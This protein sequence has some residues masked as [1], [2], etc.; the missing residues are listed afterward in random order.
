LSEAVAANVTTALQ[1]PAVAFAVMF[2]GQEIVGNW[3][4]STVTVN[5][6]VAVRP[7][8][9]V[10]VAVTTVVPTLNA[11]P[12]ARLYVTVAE[13]LS[14]AVAKNVATAVQPPASAINVMFE[15]QETVGFCA[16]TTVTRNV[17]VPVRP[18]PSVAVAVTVV[19]P[20]A[21]KLP[22][23]GTYVTVAEQ[24]SVAVAANVTVAPHTP[25]SA[26]TVIGAGQLTD[27]DWLS[28]TVT[29]NV[30][31]AVLP[32]A[33]VAVAVTTVVPSANVLPDTGL[34]ETVAP[35]QLSVAVAV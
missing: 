2:D 23:A 29:V 13:Q 28:V 10:A 7:A 20:T 6:H 5:V 17:H 30:H 1:R 3:L 4:S 14:V 11:P 16:S 8:P 21:K 32:E 9:S 15:G 31:V 34:K 18:A 22:G 24:L 35:V 19:A 26:F 33:S 27:G 12:E 25:A